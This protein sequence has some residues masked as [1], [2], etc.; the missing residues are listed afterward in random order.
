MTEKAGLQAVAEMAAGRPIILHDDF[1][2]LAYL[3]VAAAKATAEHV[4]LMA[5]EA[6]GTITIAIIGERLD[7]LRIPVI[8]SNSSYADAE[9]FAASV[10]VR[11]EGA[12]GMPARDRAATI[13]AL[14]DP[15]TQP[16]DFVRP[17]HLFPLRYDKGGVF[18][19]PR[20]PEAIVDL[21][22][23]AGMYPAGVLCAIMADTGDM[24]TQT[25]DL[26][27]LGR[28]LNVKLVSVSQ[29]LL[30]RG[31]REKVVHRIASA[32]LPTR[33]GEF[34]VLGYQCL[35]DTDEHIVVVMGD[36]ATEE[37]MPAAFLNGCVA[38]HVFDNQACGC[39]DRLQEKLER[40]SALGRGVLLYTP[41]P[42]V[43]KH[44][45]GGSLVPA[46]PQ[47]QL[48]HRIIGLQVLADLGIRR[49]VLLD[50]GEA[51]DVPQ[52]STL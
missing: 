51:V 11:Q 25:P 4:N 27:A 46:P 43:C 1:H 39:G 15:K 49:A 36:T 31:H 42:S 21:A 50:D 41:T 44:L 17:G 9:P 12:S 30:L 33:Y 7:Q 8:A 47:D 3:A 29:V 18:T 13:K 6:R 22:R 20:A 10:D 32:R 26:S 28:A 14:V 2:G 37:P 38:G 16:E 48:W 40:I 45:E 34:T 52:L 5:R 23:M 19:K 24:M 35:R